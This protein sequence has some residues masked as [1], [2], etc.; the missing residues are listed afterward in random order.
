[1][2]PAPAVI[3]LRV[4]KRVAGIAHCSK[5]RFVERLVS[6]FAVEAFNEAVLLGLSRR[7]VMP[8]DADCLNPFKDRR[9]GEL[10][11]VGLYNRL[12][13]PFGPTMICRDQHQVLAIDVIVD[14]QNARTAIVC[15]RVTHEIQAPTSVWTIGILVPNAR[16][17]PPLRRI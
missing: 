10:R 16:F 7:D 14:G 11:A 3:L 1:M 17:L 4:F 2:C 15:Q 8:I 13:H 5:Q 12:W 9:A 6:Q